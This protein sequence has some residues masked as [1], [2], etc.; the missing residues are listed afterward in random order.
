MNR[1]LWL[2]G[3]VVAAL[4]M[5]GMASASEQGKQEAAQSKTGSGCAGCCQ[6]SPNADT[7]KSCAKETPQEK[8]G[9]FRLEDAAWRLEITGSGGLPA[10][11]E[12]SDRGGDGM[13]TGTVD[14]E[15][16][17]MAYGALGL[18]LMPLFLYFEEQ[19]DVI[20]GAG[21]G[22][23]PRIYTVRNEQRGFFLEGEALALVH[24]NKFRGDSSYVDFITGG[25]VGYKCKANWHVIVKF[26]HISNAG[27][28]GDNDGVNTVGAA[29]GYTF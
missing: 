15:I 2:I 28:G 18:R 7:A 16:P 12:T 29:V 1:W 27:L 3:S 8:R 4:C 24:G 17:I 6:S 5:A 13:V 9:I 21:G 11:S 20:W 25:G 10:S 22:I 14:Y 19:G 23:A 26:E